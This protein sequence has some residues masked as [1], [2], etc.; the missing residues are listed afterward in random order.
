M[1][2]NDLSGEVAEAFA[3]LTVP[4]YPPDG[5]HLDDRLFL[6]SNGRGLLPFQA[7]SKDP[8]EQ[9]EKRRARWRRNRAAAR[10][11]AKAAA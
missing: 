3:G 9:A 8:A 6:G 5:Y 10:T 11:R 7:R 1:A 2:W 4:E